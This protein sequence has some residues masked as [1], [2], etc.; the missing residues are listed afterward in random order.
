[1]EL[2]VVEVQEI[3]SE[4]DLRNIA[5]VSLI[6]A[7]I[8]LGGHHSLV[9]QVFESMV[10]AIEEARR[11]S[12]DRQ[13]TFLLA[14]NGSR[15]PRGARILDQVVGWT[16]NGFVTS[17]SGKWIGTYDRIVDCGEPHGETQRMIVYLDASHAAP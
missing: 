1:M 3:T 17:T 6:P 5:G 4:T 10:S 14:W 15:I 11:R 9:A 2:A 16:Q 13:R 12:P 7:P 8:D